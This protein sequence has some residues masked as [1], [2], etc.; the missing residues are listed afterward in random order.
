MRQFL[1]LNTNKNSALVAQVIPCTFLRDPLL[2]SYHF[3]NFLRQFN[4]LCLYLSQSLEE[5]YEA[6]AKFTI[7]FKEKPIQSAIF[8]TG[9]IHIGSD[10]TNDLIIDSLAVAPEH[11]VVN[12][13][14]SQALIKQLNDNFPIIINNEPCKEST[15]NNSDEIVIGKHRII[16]NT[17]E[18]VVAP[19]Q[20]ETS[21]SSNMDTLNEEIEAEPNTLEAH[22]QI[23]EGKHIGRVIPLKKSM[24]RIGH[25]GK[26]VAVIA[27]RKD[28]FYISCLENND[29]LTVNNDLLQEQTI[30]LSD[31]DQVVIDNTPMQFFQD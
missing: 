8:D 21:T 14:D 15:L 9:I 25:S 28:G 2:I 3:I 22:L 4:L 6:M 1:R 5:F 18:S 13:N 24:S 7:L 30:K 12:L 11:A 20:P 10:S 29:S 19:A 27:K 23:M 16:Y 31:S 26:G 17:T